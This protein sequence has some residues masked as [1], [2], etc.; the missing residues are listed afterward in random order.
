MLKIL[1]KLNQFCAK[2]QLRRYIQGKGI[3]IGALNQPLQVNRKNAEVIY[4]DRQEV[5]SLIELN[6]ETDENKILSPDIV[7]DA[8]DLGCFSDESLDFVIARHV[9]EHIPNPIKALHEFY[10]VLK[11]HSILYI[12]LPDKRFSM[13]NERPVTQINHIVQDYENNVKISDCNDHFKEWLE[14][15]ELKKDKPIAKTL[16]GIKKH[17]IHFHVWDPD[18]MVEIF[19]YINERYNFSF[20]LKDYY[21]QKSDMNIIFIFEKIKGHKLKEKISLPLKEM[22]ILLKIYYFIFK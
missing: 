22:T 20:I 9:L 3:E 15:V 17:T 2:R 10:R 7:A 19:N 21:Y 5:K 11:D 18:S 1:I 14:F 6:P 12:S 16:D 13:D 4:V 8:E